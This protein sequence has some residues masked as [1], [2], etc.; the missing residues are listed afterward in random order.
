MLYNK[1]LAIRWIRLRVMSDDSDRK[2]LMSNPDI[3]RNLNAAE[4]EFALQESPGRAPF[5]P[6]KESCRTKNI[7]GG[8]KVSQLS[9]IRRS[10]NFITIPVEDYFPSFVTFLSRV[11][12]VAQIQL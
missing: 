9:R 7:I 4:V 8:E 6:E 12:I 10:M 3:T 5:P 2:A 1:L 11:V